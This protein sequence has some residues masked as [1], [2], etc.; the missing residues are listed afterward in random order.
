MVQ[1]QPPFTHDASAH[2]PCLQEANASEPLDAL[3]VA[4]GLRPVL[5]HINRALR[6]EAHELGV[7]STQA[8]LLAAINRSPQIGL[9]ELATQEHLTA[10][11]LVSHI[12]KLVAA[13]Q[14]ERRRANPS[15]R[16]RVELTVTP[17]GAEVLQHLRERR[18]A[19]LAARLATLPQEGLAAIAAAIE[20]LGQLVRNEA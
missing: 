20:P 8:S 14:V 11:T 16:R 2:S 12:D 19:W 5:L 15:D 7:T 4:N 9:G 17:T 3:T 6:Y 1:D 18:T 13:G 10:P